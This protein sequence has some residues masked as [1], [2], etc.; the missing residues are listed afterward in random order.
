M[1]SLINYAAH[2]NLGTSIQ[3]RALSRD[4]HEPSK[5]FSGSLNT[6]GFVVERFVK[7]PVELVV[8]FR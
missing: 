8:H 2:P 5:L 3:T 4:G 1:S 6:K 7:P